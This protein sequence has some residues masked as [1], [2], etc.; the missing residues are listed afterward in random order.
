MIRV[1]LVEDDKNL[2]FILKSSLEQMI[3]GYEVAT[4]PNGRRDWNC[5]SRRSST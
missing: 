4:A 5:W 2:C 1:L 3:G